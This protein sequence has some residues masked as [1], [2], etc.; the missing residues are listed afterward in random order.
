MDQAGRRGAV[1]RVLVA[2]ASRHVA[3]SAASRCVSRRDDLFETGSYSDR[4]LSL[5]RHRA[6]KRLVPARGDL[7]GGALAFRRRAQQ[8]QSTTN[9][10]DH[11]AKDAKPQLASRENH[12]RH[13][14]YLLPTSAM[15]PSAQIPIPIRT[16]TT[17]VTPSGSFDITTPSHHPDPR[18]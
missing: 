16:Q 13:A 11:N 9:H 8:L 17:R 3:V 15:T 2:R 6:Q 10:E 5:S 1:K 4:D 14:R 18:V 7:L 12:D